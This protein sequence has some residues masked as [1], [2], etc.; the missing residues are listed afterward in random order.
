MITNQTMI[1]GMKIKDK[2]SG[3]LRKWI[4]VALLLCLA[5]TAS[6]SLAA[7]VPNI[8]TRVVI[9]ASEQPLELFLSELFGQIGVPVRVDDSIIGSV[10]G[11]S[12]NG[13]FNDTV[14]VVF[15]D[16]AKT[17]NLSMYYDGAV[18]Y[19]YPSNDV[20]NK[21]LYMP[22]SV[23]KR[24]K[25]TAEKLALVDSNNRMK[26]S[27]VGLV[28]TG[29]HRFGEQVEDLAGAFRKQTKKTPANT[30][31]IYR[32]F[33]LRFAW[34]DDTT[35]NFGGDS[36]VIPGVASLIRRLI[37]PGA[38]GAP[39]PVARVLDSPTLDGLRGKGLQAVAVQKTQQEAK[40]VEGRFPPATLSNST[41]NSRVVADTLSNS[42]IIRDRADRMAGY[43]T[44]IE[45]LD[46]EPQMVEIEATII[47]LDTDRM[48]ELGVNWRLKGDG[49][50]MLLGNGTNSDLLLEP[51]AQ[52]TPSGDGLVTSLVLNGKA[53]FISR[54][55]ALETQGV[56]RIVSKPHVMTLSNMEALLDTKSTFFVRIAGQEEVDLFDVSVGTALR[57][58]PHVFEQ[59]GLTQIKLRVNIED[60]SASDQQVDRIPVV[61]TSKISTQ[62]IIEMGQSLLIGGLVRESKSNG[63]SKVPFLGSIPG[64]GALFR[65]TTRSTSRMERMFLITPRVSVKHVAGK[66]YNAPVLS[67]PVNDIIGSSATRMAPTRQALGLLDEAAPLKPALPEGSGL[68]SADMSV[69]EPYQLI[70]PQPVDDRDRPDQSFRQRVLENSQQIATQQAGEAEQVPATVAVKRSAQPDTLDVSAGSFAFEP[71]GDG[72]QEVGSGQPTPVVSRPLPV[73][74]APQPPQPLSADA[75]WQE[76]TQ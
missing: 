12:V 51:D 47:D 4:T 63:V 27:D 73:P 38:L 52:I 40:P 53:E 65:S 58:T 70:A 59:H 10:N 74:K 35:L 2:L 75:G 37:E 13:G 49:G 69:A 3:R 56:A 31:D 20:L 43:Q 17:F 36:V 45:S 21:I 66:R 22:A 8:D 57:V 19:V 39:E 28:V 67:G 48:R 15:G 33:K 44:L 24:V 6:V 32:V 76:V 25:R 54:I 30:H 1:N 72:W 50:E 34:A 29:A 14:E 26:I 60:G 42:I 61:E 5:T 64:I 18:V 16:I 23:A 46:K 41:A 55:R 68:D 9:N 11:G 62:A 7:T 71:P